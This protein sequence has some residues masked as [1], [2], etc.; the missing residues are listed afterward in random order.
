MGSHSAGD[1]GL[2]TA[3]SGGAPSNARGGGWVAPLDST[4]PLLSLP[5]NQLVTMQDLKQGLGPSA[6]AGAQKS[7]SNKYKLKVGAQSPGAGRR[8]QAT[9]AGTAEPAPGPP[10]GQEALHSGSRPP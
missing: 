1:G 9:A 8:R 10:A 4:A 6:A 2:W 3:G 7:A 5:A